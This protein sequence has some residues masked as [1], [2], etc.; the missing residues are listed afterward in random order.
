MQKDDSLNSLL[1]KLLHREDKKEEVEH[2]INSLL[3]HKIS[4]LEQKLE[5]QS[6]AINALQQQDRQLR[7]LLKSKKILNYKESKV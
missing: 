1:K 6:R 4:I 5:D 3:L 2:H 7:L